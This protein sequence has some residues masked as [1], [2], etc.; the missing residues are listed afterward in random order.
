MR[1]TVAAIYT[2]FQT[3]VAD[4]SRYPGDRG[5]MSG[6]WTE[7]LFVEFRRVRAGARGP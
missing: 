2:N 6:E 7:K 3:A 4:E 1:F 5:Y